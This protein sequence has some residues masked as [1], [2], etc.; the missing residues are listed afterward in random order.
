MATATVDIGDHDDGHLGLYPRCSICADTVLRHERVIA[1]F[2]N[3]D[4]TSYRGHTRP[5]AFPQ[6]GHTITRVDG[7]V[8]CRYPDC[9]K[10][11]ASPEFAPI[12][13]DCF[14]IFRKQCS[15]SASA[16]LNRLWI[17]AAWRSPW[18]GAQPIYLSVPVVDKD[19]LKRI[20]GF[21]GLPRLYTLPL[22]LL[23][24][25][26]QY[27]RHSLLWRCIP[28]LQ[29]ADYVSATKPEPPITV[30]LRELLFWERSGKFER[31]TAS[32][33]PLQILRLTV[34]SAGISKV[35]RL[36]SPPT[37]I[38][39]CTSRSA[40][41]VQD[42]ASISKVVVQLKDGRLRLN[43]PTSLRTLPIWNTPAPPSLDLCKAYPA[44]LASCQ[45]ICTVEMDQI[46]GITFFFSL[47]QLFGIHVHRSEGSCAMDTFTR[48]FPN[49]L[50]R[51]IVW[52]YL[53]ISQ[54]DRIFVLGIR[55]ALQSRDLNVLVRTELIGDIIIGLQSKGDVKDRC[56]A[57]SAPLTMIYSEPREGRPVRFFGAYCRPPLDQALPKPF[58]LEKPGSCPIDDD[59]YFSWAP[60]CGV[61]S[62]LVFYDQNTGFCRGI[63]FRYQNGGSRAVGQCRLYVDPAE[64]VD[65]PVRLCFRTSSCPSRWNRMR[66][67]VQVKFKQGARINRIEKDIEGWESRPMK[68]LVKYWFTTE[69]S[70]LVVES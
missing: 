50:R 45:T 20:S 17:L 15:V 40:F 56:L 52:I 33:P 51:T 10:C 41:I 48:N 47:G 53:P 68:G 58:R 65:R 12:H 14:E 16:A 42:E 23:E 64:S 59:A 18:R 66:Y 11:A 36:P 3:G 26:R 25:T 22:E 43:L 49:R 30:P 8:L 63:V 34:D 55:E 1:L 5:F 28:A 31:V 57:A 6:P 70:F 13:F 2:G 38:G 62:T 27:S 69:S 9:R 7:R 67:M 44:D 37:Y 19:T 60:L 24:I 4:S 61:S 39:K 32:Q 54:H 46:R 21:C 29:L 35:E